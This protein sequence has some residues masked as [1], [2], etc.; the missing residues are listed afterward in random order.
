[1][2]TEQVELLRLGINP[3]D[4]KT[5]MMVESALIWL[6]DNTTLEFDINS[7][8]DLQG[9]KGNV[10]L[11]INKYLEVMGRDSSVSSESING[12]SQTFNTSQK[13]SELLWQY[14]DELLGD[15]VCRVKFYPAERYWC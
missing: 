4:D 3:I 6:Q 1:M 15:M 2:T 7:N 10:R 8:E 12:L 14:A 13:A 9:L 5:A 11:F